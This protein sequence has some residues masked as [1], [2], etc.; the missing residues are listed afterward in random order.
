MIRKVL[1]AAFCL[2]ASLAFPAQKVTSVEGITE[3]RLDNGLK[4][5]LFPDTSKQ[6]IT[7]N[8]TYLVGSRHENYGETGMAHLFE[9]ML[10]LGSTKHPN[11][12]AEFTKYGARPNGST[13]FDRTNY[14]ETFPATDVNLRWA[15]DLESDRMVNSF[16]AKASLDKEMTVVRNEFERGEND[17]N[18]VLLQ[19][20]MATAFQWHNYGKSTIGS[21]ADLENVPIEK[22]QA[23]YKR[24]YQPDNA[25]LVV[26][27]KIEEAKTLALIEEYFGKIPKP[28]RKLEKTYT[29]DPDQDGERTVTV[30]RVG[31]VQSVLALYRT[32]DGSHPDNAALDVLTSVL[33]DAPAGRLHK[34]L[35]ET[36]KAAGVTGFSWQLAEPGVMLFQARVRKD[37]SLDEAKNTMLKVIH[38]VVNEHPTKE[39][40]E[41]VKTAELK[42]IELALNDSE[43]IGLALSSTVA[44]GD[45]KLLFI[46]RD[47]LRKV[48]PEDVLRVAQKYIKEDNR[49]MAYF[50]P[51]DKPDR[52]EIPPVTDIAALTKDYKGAA[53]VAQGEAF[54]P[55]PANIERRLVRSKLSNGMK[56][57]LLPKKTRGESVHGLLTMHYGDQTSL[58]GQGRISE[59]TAQ[60]LLRGT[61]THTRQQLHDELDR[62][63]ARVSINGGPNTVRAS[64]ETTRPNLPAVLKL[65]AEILKEPNFPESEWEQLKQS[66]LA[67]VEARKSDPA[68]LATV[69]LQQHLN[70]YPKD[71][72]RYVMSNEEEVAATQGATLPAAKA[73]HQRFYGTQSAEFV[74]VGDFDAAEQN[75]LAEELFGSWKGS[76]PFQRAN[77]PY[78]KLN[79]ASRAIETPD[80]ANALITAGMQIPVNDTNPDY[81][82]LQL[83]NYLLGASSNSRLWTRIRTKEGYSYGVGSGVLARSNGDAGLFTFQAIAAPSNVSKVQAAFQEELSKLFKEGIPADEF[84]QAK[85][86]LLQQFGLTRGQ[87]QSLAGLIS[88]NEY[89]GRT[90]DFQAEKERKISALTPEQVVDLMKKYID[91]SQITYIKAGDFKK[92]A[93]TP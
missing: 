43:R 55:T 33:T 64:I 3:Y 47:Q 62:L 2:G 69:A 60:M 34:A 16:V 22:L 44:L 11:I 63:K 82:A 35:V 53:P 30:K 39:E 51:V 48:T 84:E 81:P 49:T 76:A 58:K 75:R 27:G 1:A 91:A 65:L 31:D 54:D 38:D 87:D 29:L 79:V 14:F 56:L 6:T 78:Q 5:L 32:P 40:V 24:Y 18:R 13:N 57:A 83:G 37:A 23:F 71:D 85:T 46:Q 67:G 52:A 41:R 45:W 92:V 74:L 89:E 8:V 21:K 20:A 26:A 77:Y 68:A 42:Q 66:A 17:P 72:P 70:P 50:R 9:H 90:M 19:R 59:L 28:T 80:K 93:V 86:G 36:K 15:L 61:K 10:F 73:F 4:V 25:V 88:T 7:V 12:D